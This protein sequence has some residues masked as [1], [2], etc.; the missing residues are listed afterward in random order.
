MVR[1]N[2]LISGE[3]LKEPL[4]DVFLTDL[5]QISFSLLCPKRS[6]VAESLHG[7]NPRRGLPELRSG[8]PPK[9]GSEPP[10]STA[11]P[12]SK[13]NRNVLPALAKGSQNRRFCVTKSANEPFLA[14]APQKQVYL[15]HVPMPGSSFVRGRT[16]ASL[17]STEQPNKLPLGRANQTG[18]R[19]FAL[20]SKVR[21]PRRNEFFQGVASQHFWLPK[22]SLRTPEGGSES[23]RLEPSPWVPSEPKWRLRRPW[24]CEQTKASTEGRPWVPKEPKPGMEF[25]NRNGVPGQRGKTTQHIILNVKIGDYVHCGDKIGE[26]FETPLRSLGGNRNGVP[27]I[28]GDSGRVI[29]LTKTQLTLQ[30][31]QPVLFYSEATSHVRENEWVQRGS[32]ILTLTHQTLVTGDIV[33]GIPRIEQLF[34]A[35]TS[36]SSALPDDEPLYETLHSQ[37]REIFRRNWSLLPLPTAVRQALEEIQQIIVESIQKVYLS[38]GVLIA[39][40]HIEI[41]VKQMTSKGQII[42]NGNTGFIINEVLPLQKIENANLTTSGKKAVYAPAVVGLTRAALNSDSFIS[43]ASFQETTRVLTRDAVAGKSDFLRGLKEKVVIG[44]LISAGTGLDLFFLY[45]LLA[46]NIFDTTCEKMSGL[47]K[48]RANKYESNIR[49]I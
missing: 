34:E 20:R 31:T 49:R 4:L 43:A 40:K 11:P 28:I 5:E 16:R 17:E 10:D 29:T 41:I 13:S 37:A 44:D 26:F 27:V 24:V 7:L 48:G 19:L 12:G 39:D 25:G 30:K 21:T 8:Y 15:K 32:P 38:Q 42:D 45:T 36:S 47:K 46:E 35:V 3:I 9:G 33:Q 22:A 23:V 2:K 6:W 14:S 1:K 18:R